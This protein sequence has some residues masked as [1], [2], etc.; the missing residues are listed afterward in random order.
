[1][2]SSGAAMS[3]SQTHPSQVRV[4]GLTEGRS[5]TISIRVCESDLAALDGWILRQ[6]D[7]KPKR[8]EAVRALMHAGVNGSGSEASLDEN[9]IAA[10]PQLRAA[11]G[12]LGISQAQLASA[13]GLPIRTISEAES[14]RQRQGVA[15]STLQQIVGAYQAVGVEF[16]YGDSPGVRLRLNSAIR[17]NEPGNG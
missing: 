6:A 12:L 16:T 13:I 11:R 3:G 9:R 17:K 1:M 5:K 14:N 2:F 10:P 8:S 15:L 4:R 7:P